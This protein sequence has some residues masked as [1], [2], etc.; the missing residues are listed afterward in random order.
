MTVILADTS[1]WTDH[2]RFENPVF[3]DRLK[4]GR[5]LMHELVIGELVMGNL[6]NRPAFLR[7]LHHINRSVRASD[8]E[9]MRLIED[10]HLYGT[11]LGFIDAHLLAS[12]LLT[13]EVMLWTRDRR[14]NAAAEHFG[15]AAQLHH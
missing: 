12:V 9:V 4:H 7:R 11:G 13:D 5:I 1:V 8:S 14:L 6:P 15:R 2:L 3:A 10:N